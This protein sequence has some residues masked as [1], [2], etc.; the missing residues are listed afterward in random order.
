MEDI[1]SQYDIP[2]PSAVV[3]PQDYLLAKREDRLFCRP[4]RQSV[5]FLLYMTTRFPV[6]IWVILYCHYFV[7][8]PIIWIGPLIWFSYMRWHRLQP[9]FKFEFFLLILVLLV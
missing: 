1:C 7:Y 9:S 2:R 6:L 8:F 3:V 4:T 5:P